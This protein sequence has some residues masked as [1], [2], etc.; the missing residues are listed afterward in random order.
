VFRKPEYIETVCPAVQRLKFKHWG[1]DAVI[2][3]EHDI[4]KPAG[5]YA[6]LQNAARRAEFMADVNGLME[7]APFTLFAAVIRKGDLSRAYAQPANPYTIALEFGLE[8]LLEHL[9]GLGQAEHLTHGGGKAGQTGGCGIGT[10][11]PPHLRRRERS[12]TAAAL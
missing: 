8:R 10:G 1:H 12:Q 2:L 11:I 5:A 4:R 3:H 7:A 9:A 6:F